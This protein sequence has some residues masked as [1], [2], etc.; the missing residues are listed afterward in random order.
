MPMKVK[1]H[2]IHP[3]EGRRRGSK[4]YF[5]YISL[6]EASFPGLQIVG[7]HSGAG[8]SIPGI[9]REVREGDELQLGALKA[10]VWPDDN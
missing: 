10:R 7:H 9:D 4:L 5:I 6:R 2:V 3:R 8:E 1:E